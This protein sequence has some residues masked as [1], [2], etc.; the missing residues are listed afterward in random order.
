MYW[1]L[2]RV[3][4]YLITLCFIGVIFYYA[5]YQSRDI[6]LGPVIVVNDLQ[7]GQTLND[8]V[9]RII[10]SVK[11]AKEITLDGRAIFIDLD[12][13][14]AEELLLSPGYNIIEIVARDAE[15]HGTKKSFE[16]VYAARGDKVVF[17]S[18]SLPSF[19]TQ[20]LPN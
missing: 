15:G 12:G 19:N 8:P 13:N 11:R 5:Y 17:S 6:L 18:T 1:T 2:K 3:I 16:L 20:E 7:N 4:S 14:F 10:G 9:V